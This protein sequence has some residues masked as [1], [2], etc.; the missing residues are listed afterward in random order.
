MKNTKTEKS[1]KISVR[2]IAIM[3]VMT[4]LEVVLTRLLAFNTLGM[5][6]GFGFVPVVAVAILYGPVCSAIVGGLGDLVGSL[7]FPVGA[8]FP[9]FT[10][11]AVITGAVWGLFLHGRTKKLFFLRTVIA[12]LINNL[13][14]GLL[15]NSYWISALFSPKSYGACIVSRL[16]EYAIMIP[17][18]LILIPIIA[19][20]CDKFSEKKSAKPAAPKMTYGEALEYIHSISWTWCKPGL[21]RIT[22]LCEKLGNPQ[23]SLRFI[24]IAGTNGKGSTASMTA[25][26]LGKAGYSVGLFT[27]PYVDTFNERIRLNGENISDGDLAE[28]TEYVKQYADTMVDKPTEFELITAIGLEYYKRKK[29]DY[30]VFECG[31]GGMFDSTNV[32]KNSAVSVITGIDL[33]HT[34]LLGDTTAK[35]AWEKAGIIKEGVPVIFGEGDESAADVIKAEA[36]AKS[37]RF[38]RTDYSRVTNVKSDLGG[39]SFVFDGE[40]YRINLLGLY[41]MH[42]A[43]TVLTAVEVLR[44]SGAA[45]PEEAVR[46]GLASARWNARFEVLSEHPLVVYDGAHNPQG[47]AGAVENIR[48]YLAPLTE[49]GRIALL[50]GVMADKDH[51]KMIEMLAPYA[52]SV[53]AVTPQNARSLDSAAV[54][55]EFEEH[56]ALGRAF[57]TI[58]EGV[59]AAVAY[60]RDNGVPLL[61]LG[62]LYM[63]ADVKK[64]VLLHTE[65]TEI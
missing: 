40:E 27:S 5:K 36:K 48:H 3:S 33:D 17:L 21:E 55:R 1:K 50:M 61:C 8:Y 31:L 30:V 57:G 42:N 52:K 2:T 56:G 60:A 47:I 62:S 53:F 10:L 58:D 65:I 18:N 9:G 7:L 37:S 15:I 45:I 64:S 54:E 51:G 24:H 25:S 32:I 43:A 22:E 6:I 13:G 59:G 39:T 23:D 38:I 26:I 41:Q 28:V 34:A 20:V 46:D 29:C 4:A 11:T 16:P 63:Y 44:E 12:S 14:V 35:I 19:R 49:D